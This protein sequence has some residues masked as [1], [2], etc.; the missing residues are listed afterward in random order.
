MRPAKGAGPGLQCSRDCNPNGGP[1]SRAS[2]NAKCHVLGRQ[3]RDGGYST[4]VRP[5]R[6]GHP[7]TPQSRALADVP[8]RS[9][10]FVDDTSSRTTTSS[11]CPASTR[12]I[13]T[14]TTADALTRSVRCLSA[15]RQVSSPGSSSPRFCRGG[16]R[17]TATTER[18]AYAIERV[19]QVRSRQEC[20]I[21][22]IG[23]DADGCPVSG[24]GNDAAEAAMPL[25]SL[26]D[27]PA[28]V[29]T[30]SSAD[31]SAG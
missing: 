21:R 2:G 1:D 27:D 13:S 10:A 8:V 7:L 9:G 17:S 29:R 12:S 14:S 19:S 15:D 31:V 11:S 5:E 25:R 20:A 22:R 4:R 18:G 26:R 3:P 24:A 16:S 23:S 30:E 6:Q 28:P